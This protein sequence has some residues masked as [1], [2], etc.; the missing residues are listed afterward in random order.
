MEKSENAKRE[1]EDE[2]DE[3]PGVNTYGLENPPTCNLDCRFY[4][5]RFPEVDDIVMAQ[6][7]DVQE[8]MGA[9]VHLLEYNNISGLIMSTEYASHTFSLEP[10]TRF[11]QVLAQAH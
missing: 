5:K 6:I 9:Y 10:L 1:Y 4:E 8:M 11:T 7:Y 2:E 3:G